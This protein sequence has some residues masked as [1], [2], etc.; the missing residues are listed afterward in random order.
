MLTLRVSPDID[1]ERLRVAAEQIVRDHPAL[2]QHLEMDPASSRV[3]TAKQPVC[4]PAA[5]TP[6]VSLSREHGGDVVLTLRP[7][8]GSTDM[9]GLLRAAEALARAYRCPDQCSPEETQPEMVDQYYAALPKELDAGAEQAF[10][11][12]GGRPLTAPELA[13]VLRLRTTLPGT[14]L[15]IPVDLTPE[16]TDAIATAAEIAGGSVEAALLTVWRLLLVRIAPTETGSLA[17]FVPGQTTILPD[18]IGLLGRCVP[19][20]VRPAAT[21]LRAAIGACA[22]EL[23]AAVRQ[24]D[25]F[26]HPRPGDAATVGF[27]HADAPAAL[28][29]GSGLSGQITAADA[30]TERTVLD[31]CSCRAGNRLGLH[32]DLDAAAMDTDISG[33]LATWLARMLAHLPEA[34]DAPSEQ[35]ATRALAAEAVAG[36]TSGHSV[37]ITGTLLDAFD[38]QAERTPDAIAA[39]D[40]RTTLTYRTLNE[41]TLSLER[42]L[43][44]CGVTAGDRVAVCT[45]RRVPLL[46]ALLAILRCGAAFVPLDPALPAHRIEDLLY[47]AGPRLIIAD[48]A[49][50][51]VLPADN[52]VSV[53]HLNGLQPPREPNV[54]AQRHRPRP[55]SIA[56]LIYTSGSTGRPK[57]VLITH[58]ALLNYLSWAASHYDVVAGSGTLVHSSIAVDMTI[59]SLFLPLLAGRTVILLPS[60]EP[61]D[62]AAA[63]SRAESLSPLKITPGGLRVLIMLVNGR[64]LARAVRHLVLGGEPL[65]PAALSEVDVAGL[66]VTNEYGPT[67]ATVGCCAYT[68]RTGMPLPDPV[69]IGRPIWNTTLEARLPTGLRALPG[70][71]GELVISGIGVT[72]GYHERPEETAAQFMPGD[73][74]YR[75]GDLAALGHG[76]RWTML[77]RTD[78]QLKIHG[79]RV[80]PGEI[81]AVLT[82]DPHIAAAAVVRTDS[83]LRAFVVPSTRVEDSELL[84]DRAR[85]LAEQRLPFY[86]RPDRVHVLPALPTGSNGKINRRALSELS[87]PGGDVDPISP[88]E[89]HQ[90]VLA[91]AWQAVLGS[92]PSGPDAN[93]FGE[94]ADSVTAVLLATE[95][96]RSGL[97][98]TVHDV[99]EQRT[100]RRMAH[101]ARLAAEPTAAP[102][103]GPVPLTVH[104]AGFFATMPRHPNRWVLC[105]S[106]RAPG[107]VDSDRLD[108]ALT[109]T[110]HAHP[111][112][113]S[114]FTSDGGGEWNTALRRPGQ[115]SVSVLDLDTLPLPEQDAQ[116]REFLRQQEETIDLATGTMVRLCLLRG[117]RTGHRV[118]WIAHHLV[119]D[120]VSLRLLDDDLWR[121]Y[122]DA[123]SGRIPRLIP[124]GYGEWLARHG[125]RNTVQ[126]RFPAPGGREGTGMPRTISTTLPDELRQHLEDSCG[127]PSGGVVELAAVLL[128]GLV[129]VRPDLAPAV[130]VELHGRDRGEHD[131]TGVVGW[132]TE[133]RV[134]RAPLPLPTNPADL[135]ACLRTQV[136]RRD[137]N[138]G[139]L[140]P[141][142]LN[143]LGASPREASLKFLWEPADGPEPLFPLE[144]VVV[145]DQGGL[146]AHWRYSPGWMPR[147]VVLRL[148]NAVDRHATRIATAV[149]RQLGEAGGTP[150][151]AGLAPA[152]LQRLFT[153][154]ERP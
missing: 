141:V 96:S 38:A 50:A 5:D 153:A 72:A 26:I 93:F 115:Q 105:Y 4:G 41:A 133:F 35:L 111:A 131:L 147:S 126:T 123:A 63:V 46:T 68:F 127:V 9:T 45:S 154:F 8:I 120:V 56:Y 2:R 146:R 80:E 60:D 33:R 79:Y 106:A 84:V 117:G 142:A 82:D 44:V 137:G 40:D 22:H 67:E 49:G 103:D 17:V 77:G 130:S 99:L 85:I 59:T 148:A 73:G 52:H 3:W 55:G 119:T 75:T 14:R 102:I 28:T 112:L 74:A 122:R 32:L 97:L 78:E 94:G 144:L 143:Y 53:L 76:G 64:Q 51:R 86:A 135:V 92:P 139:I 71:A 23:D 113:W 19:L 15:R 21:S 30:P 61:A 140:P 31:L 149:S 12:P 81:E 124:D 18:V 57:G 6:V 54:G 69:P 27:R 109:A 25:F 152:D 151:T 66:A 118:A 24:A 42:T 90:Q 29:F 134:L 98:L 116:T 47:D 150:K 37:T 121:A 129:E 88:E 48:E 58:A 136:G 89:P 7:G 39:T 87:L 65:T 16:T 104:Q 83:V 145:R 108:I 132:L 95:V 110:V 20:P 128:A 36:R 101:R 125:D 1:K 10:W 107:D 11:R 13:L 100:L 70:T 138:D 114:T 91:R 62:L 34:L 43:T